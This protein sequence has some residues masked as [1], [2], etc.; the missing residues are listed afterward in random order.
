M[1]NPIRYITKRKIS[2][3]VITKKQA[4]KIK[5]TFWKHHSGL[6]GWQEKIKEYLKNA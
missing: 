2:S 4:E 3:P 6:V 1:P 5:E